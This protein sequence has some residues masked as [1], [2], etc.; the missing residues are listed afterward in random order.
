M[1]NINKYIFCMFI[2]ALGLFFFTSLIFASKL[3]DQKHKRVKIISKIKDY[4]VYASFYAN[5]YFTDGERNRIY[6][7]TV[8][9]CIDFYAPMLYEDFSI[10]DPPKIDIIIYDNAEEMCRILSINCDNIPMGIYYGEVINVL[11]PSEWIKHDEEVSIK[12]QFVREGPLI[13]ELS[14]YITDLK[15]GGN[16]SVWL[17]EGNA[18]YYE[19]KYAAFELRD[20]LKKASES[21]SVDDLEN[22]FRDINESKAYRRSFDIIY[23]YVEKYGE[24]KMQNN[25]EKLKKG[26]RAKELFK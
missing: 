3:I 2:I 13:H 16:Y 24:A 25:L 17:T 23:D 11:S 1:K 14:H 10:P 20:D 19:N 9:N 26:H 5:I 12:K 7:D 18:L 21:I 4:S 22:N 8:A 15:T 6:A